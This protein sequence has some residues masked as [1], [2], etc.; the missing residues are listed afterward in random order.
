MSLGLRLQYSLCQRILEYLLHCKCLAEQSLS[1]TWLSGCRTLHNMSVDHAQCVMHLNCNASC[2]FTHSGQHRS[3]PVRSCSN[4]IGAT[5][6]ELIERRRPSLDPDPLLCLRSPGTSSK[7]L[8]LRGEAPACDT[9]LLP[10]P[11]PILRPSS[12]ACINNW[13]CEVKAVMTKIAITSC[14]QKACRRPC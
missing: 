9:R 10:C 14:M 11:C 5:L 2:T 7:E 12:T 13:A 6:L 4:C 3:V 8:C 1:N